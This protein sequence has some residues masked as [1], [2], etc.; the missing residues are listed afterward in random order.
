MELLNVTDQ[1]FSDNS[2]A[3]YQFY[4]YQPS[5]SGTLNYNDETKI[6]I[7]DLDAYTAPCN[8]YLCIEGK[9]MKEDGADAVALEFINNGISFYF[10]EL[11]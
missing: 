1:L 7:Q 2:I 11:L 9:L 4:A 10:V 6:P 3:E 8:S 5:I